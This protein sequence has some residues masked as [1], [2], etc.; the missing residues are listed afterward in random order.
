MKEAFEQLC[1]RILDNSL[2]SPE[3][4]LQKF[5]NPKLVNVTPR[6]SGL[7]VSKLPHTIQHLRQ[8]T[9]LIFSALVSRVLYFFLS[10]FVKWNNLSFFSCVLW[11]V[12]CCSLNHLFISVRSCKV[13]LYLILQPSTVL[14]LLLRFS[15]SKSRVLIPLS[16]A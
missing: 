12:L 7:S 1:K 9:E 2:S 15:D 14:Y 8:T 4:N 13:R 11:V 16:C 10:L 6:S 5:E 3:P